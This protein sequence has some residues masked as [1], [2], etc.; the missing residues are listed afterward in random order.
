MGDSDDDYENLTSKRRGKFRKERED[1]IMSNNGENN[2][3]EDHRRRDRPMINDRDASSRYTNNNRD[4]HYRRDRS[5][6]MNINRGGLSPR[7]FNNRY[8]PHSRQQYS[9]RSMS[10]PPMSQ[11]QSRHHYFQGNNNTNDHYGS[12]AFGPPSGHPHHDNPYN[13]RVFSPPPIPSQHGQ[14]YKPHFM[15]GYGNGQSMHQQHY[16]DNRS[17]SPLGVTNYYDQEHGQKKTEA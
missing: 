6:K 3:N 4:Y 15:P 7:Q 14:Y 5:P 16:N 9:N 11:Q 10:P 17:I 13:K 12:R 8:P 1:S 2:L